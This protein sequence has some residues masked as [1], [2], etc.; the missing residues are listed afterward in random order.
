MN[1][2]EKHFVIKRESLDQT[3][4]FQSILQEACRL[5]LLTDS[6]FEYIQLQGIQLLA[7]QTERYTGGESSS[8]KVETAQTIMHS[9]FFYNWNLS[10]EFSV[11]GPKHNGP[12]TKTFIITA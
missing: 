4:Y 10:K 8:V 11:S 3:Y 1:N 2:L 5:K 6:E 12:K 9:I 7:K